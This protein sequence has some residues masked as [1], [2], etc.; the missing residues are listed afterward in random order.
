MKFALYFVGLVILFVCQRIESNNVVNLLTPGVIPYNLG[1][2][3]FNTLA[4]V[5]YPLNVIFPSTAQR[6]TITAFIRSGMNSGSA[7]VNLW[8]WTECPE[9]GVRDVKF[10]RAFRYHQTAISFDSET[11]DFLY[12]SSKPILYALTDNISN[13][14]QL[15]LYAVA[16]S[17]V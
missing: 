17:K 6:V 12:C 1:I 5:S 8:L 15:E 10:K 3:H 2:F 11:L 14:I 7:E 4:P 9:L 13:A 16:H